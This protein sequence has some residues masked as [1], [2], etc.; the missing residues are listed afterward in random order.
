MAESIERAG[1][2]PDDINAVNAHAAATVAGDQV[3]ADALMSV[4]NQN[5]PPVTA[6]KSFWGHA[7]GASSAIESIFT[8]IGMLAEQIPPTINHKP[9]SS[10]PLDCV[11][12][13]RRRLSQE[14]VLKNA[15]GFSGCNACVVFRR[16]H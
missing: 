3:E 5:V 8:I 4:F 11:S 1:L 15:F 2:Q 13:G 10:I 14:H 16:V 9:D 7:M 12:E 6:N